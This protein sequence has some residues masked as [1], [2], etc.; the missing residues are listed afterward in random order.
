[1][2]ATVLR[3]GAG[4]TGLVLAGIVAYLCLWPIPA[5]PVS[6]HALTPPGYVGAHAPNTRLTGLRTI[7]LG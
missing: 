1:M 2:K 6:W 5:E 3:R 7:P 4:A